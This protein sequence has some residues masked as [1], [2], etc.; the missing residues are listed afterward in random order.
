MAIVT[1]DFDGTL[2]QGNSFKIMFQVGKKKFTW[3]QWLIVS[4]GLIK[5]CTIGL[6][7]GKQAFKHLFFISF[8]KTFKG[9]TKQQL[10][11]FFLEL[12]NVGMKDV[13]MKLVGKIKEHQQNGDTVILLSGALKPFL[14]MFAKQLHL[15][16]HII[17]TELELNEESVC[18]G[19][20]GSIINGEE[21]V[22]KVQEW[23]EKDE[24]YKGNTSLEI[25]A[26]AD[27]ESDIPL[28]NFVNIPIVVNPNEEM[29]SIAE[30][31]KWPIFA[32]T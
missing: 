11:E 5:A 7:K 28:L 31:N 22:R 10:D 27:S 3:K 32:S 25:W 6:I 21:K 12:V 30:Q 17:S 15:H 16:V 24:K 2:Y 26:Y 9:Q 18:T 8:A 19:K 13:N 1:V 4:A 23:I 29:K 20:I 14:E